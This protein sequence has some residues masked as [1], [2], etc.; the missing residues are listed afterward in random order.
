MDITHLKN[1]IQQQLTSVSGVASLQLQN[2]I[3]GCFI[4]MED[5][6]QKTV[7]LAD[8]QL[9]GPSYSFNIYEHFSEIGVRYGFVMDTKLILESVSDAYRDAWLQTFKDLSVLHD[10]EYADSTEECLIN[11]IQQMIPEEDAYFI[12][13]LETGSLPQSW[14][15]KVLTLLLPEKKVDEEP[16][17]TAVS[18]AVTEKPITKTP[19]K[20]VSQGPS[21]P[22]HLA[23][24]RRNVSASDKKYLA[25][26]RRA[27]RIQQ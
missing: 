1:A 10:I 7:E 9:V 18:R 4:I 26:T 2:H 25:K 11:L 19:V 12:H 8:H 23:Y 22:K 3:Y 6:A 17:V 13:A 27:V 20:A 16:A 15:Q 14:V 5:I 21:K 24:T